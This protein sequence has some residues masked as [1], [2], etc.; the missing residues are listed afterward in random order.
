MSHVILFMSEDSSHL[1]AHEQYI[2]FLPYVPLHMGGGG[3]GGMKM[4][5]KWRRKPRPT[6]MGS[7]WNLTT[8]WLL[9]E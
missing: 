8:T 3:I 6:T 5:S 9:K 2:M 4:V 1:K 7:E